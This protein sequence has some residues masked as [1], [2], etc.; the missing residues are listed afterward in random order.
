M[1][2]FL[3][4]L[5]LISLLIPL[6]I[7]LSA[8]T[9]KCTFAEEWT[10]DETSHWHICLNES[11]TEISEKGD[12]T[13]DN[14]VTES[15]ATQEADGKKVYTCTVCNY[16]R[17]ETVEFTGLTRVQWDEVFNENIFENVTYSETSVIS[18]EGVE[19]TSKSVYKFEKDKVYATLTI[20]G[21]SNS[22]TVTGKDATEFKENMWESLEPMIQYSS[23][24][25]NR[26]TKSYYMSW[27][28]QIPSLEET[29]ESINLKI[30]DGKLAEIS[31]TCKMKENDMDLNVSSTVLFT[32]YGKTKAQQSTPTE[33][34]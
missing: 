5:T 28:V 25:Y 8:C 24:K 22:E 6:T 14:G 10:N 13:W 18:A 11:C 27:P 9:H 31:F 12:H 29:A 3:S 20:A 30:K 33:N 32:D 26:E 17:T 34:A 19:I 7:G 23:F 15:E 4:V 16:K 1:K 2:R 21:Q